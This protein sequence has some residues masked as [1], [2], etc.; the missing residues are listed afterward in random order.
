M[1]PKTNTRSTAN[2]VANSAAEN[3][4]VSAADNAVKSAADSDADRHVKLRAA[5]DARSNG[6][7][8]SHKERIAIVGFGDLGARLCEMLPCDRWHCIGL[9]RNIAALPE[10]VEGARVDLQDPE[11]L[12]VLAECKPDAL[13]VALSPQDRSAAGYH[14]GFA[15]AMDAIVDGLGAHQPRRAFFVSSTRVYAE[16]AGGWVDEDGLLAE[17]DPHAKAI[18]AAERRFTDGLTNAV[19]LRAAGLYGNS[20][21]PMIRRVAEGRLSPATPPR[22]GNR[23]HRDDVAGAIAHLLEAPIKHRVINLVDDAPVA[24]QEMEAWLCAEMGQEYAPPTAGERQVPAHK[25]I[26]NERLHASAYALQYANYQQGYAAA[27][28]QLRLESER[29]NSLNL[30]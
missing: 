6:R 19:V 13:V 5:S 8:A 4:A 14:A 26:R 7:N 15:Q 23:I 25:R 30:D 1:N 11:S 18:I 29:Q 27:L 16:V 24:L 10:G 12:Q 2:S 28:K 22:Y 17:T 20:P 9:R 21:G 3:V